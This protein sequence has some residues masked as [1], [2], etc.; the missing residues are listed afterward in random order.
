MAIL[1]IKL[2]PDPIL[3]KKS[4]P[5]KMMDKGLAQLVKNMSQT[6][7][8]QPGGIGIA[9]PQ[10][11]IGKRVVLIDVSIKDPS[12][13]LEI[14]INPRIIRVSGEV[15]SREGCMSLPD[16]TATVKRASKVLVEWFDEQGRKHS[17]LAQG[18][19]AI[20]IQHEIDHLD[21]KLFIDR[22]ACLKTDVFPRRR[23]SK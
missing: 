22:V 3:R 20:C 5:I 1:P 9:A 11:G 15:L 16:Y 2:F 23:R 18:I 13:E 21:G 10:I 19:E 14:M 17:R 4:L 6:L 12:R 7:Y 8:T